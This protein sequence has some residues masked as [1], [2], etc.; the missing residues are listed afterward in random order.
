M[1]RRSK[2]IKIPKNRDIEEL[3][4]ESEEIE[5]MKE[6]K[7]LEEGKIKNID[8]GTDYLVY[9][10]KENKDEKELEDEAV[11]DE[12]Q[13]ETVEN[14]E[15]SKEKIPIRV[16]KYM[17]RRDA[18]GRDKQRWEDFQ[19][20]IE[21]VQKLNSIKEDPEIEEF[22]T[23]VKSRTDEI[24]K[25]QEEMEKIKKQ[26]EKEESFRNKYKAYKEGKQQKED[27]KKEET[28]DKKKKRLSGTSMEEI[29]KSE[30]FK[31]MWTDSQEER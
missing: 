2:K 12:K 18:E 28:N 13:Q 19:R 25:K 7:V 11:N 9:E 22:F 4:E 20:A 8:N 17:E 30:E 16:K 24:L 3:V 5:K 10:E 31:N 23:N 29:L 14:N 1:S 15:D 21:K 26:Q 27:A 6:K